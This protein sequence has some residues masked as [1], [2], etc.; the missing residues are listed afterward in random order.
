MI[1]ATNLEWDDSVLEFH[2]KKQAVNTLSTTQVRKGVYK[3]S[4]RAWSRYENYLSPLVDLLGERTIYKI[5]TSLHGYKP[6]SVTELE[7]Q[8]LGTKESSST[9][10]FEQAD[11]G[12]ESQLKGEL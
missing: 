6:P 8:E 2:K 9:A 1:N 3:D 10:D 5:K 4:L 11:D 7:Q 12:E